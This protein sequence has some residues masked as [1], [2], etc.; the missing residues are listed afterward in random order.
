MQGLFSLSWAAAFLYAVFAWRILDVLRTPVA[1]VPRGVLYGAF[2][3]LVLH[4]LAVYGAVFSDSQVH[5]GFELALSC[6]LLAACFVILVESAVRRVTVLTG[7]VLLLA[8]PA[9][10]VPEFFEAPVMLVAPSFAFKAHIGFALGAYGFIVDAAVQ[11]VLLSV[12][13]RQM[14]HPDRSVNAG[15]L[16][17]MPDLMAMERILFRIVACAFTCLS[18]VLIFGAL[19]TREVWHVAI[20]F[21]HKTVLTW[22]SWLVFAVLLAGRRFLHWRGRVALCWFWVGTAILAVA[23]LVY[24]FVI[25]V[26]FS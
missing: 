23:Y 3:A 21:D 4:A 24:R 7:F 2:L 11:A 12:F 20:G 10:L 19:T 14:K 5:F 8:C 13:S 15:W 17:N 25:E 26:V 18:G 1:T 9:V 6:A 22:L 16:S